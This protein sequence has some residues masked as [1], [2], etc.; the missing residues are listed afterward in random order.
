MRSPSA[1]AAASSASAGP[2]GSAGFA[3]LQLGTTK[4]PPPAAPLCSISAG[5]ACRK[6]SG[7]CIRGRVL[8][9]P[10]PDQLQACS[11]YPPACGEPPNRGM[12]ASRLTTEGVTALPGTDFARERCTRR[13][14]HKT[15]LHR[16][17]PPVR[18]LTAK[19]RLYPFR[20]G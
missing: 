13:D 3:H 14:R 5:A 7:S 18:G 6:H 15:L 16:F 9:H 19:R 17:T 10:A 2:S 1:S 4:E 20:G 11:R 12:P 8:T